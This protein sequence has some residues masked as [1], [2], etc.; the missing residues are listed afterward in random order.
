MFTLHIWNGIL[1]SRMDERTTLKMIVLQKLLE[2]N[3]KLSTMFFI[4]MGHWELLTW[5]GRRQM[6]KIC[7]MRWIFDWNLI[8]FLKSHWGQFISSSMDLLYQRIQHK[9]LEV[10]LLQL[11]PQHAGWRSRIQQWLQINFPSISYF[12]HISYKKYLLESLHI[13]KRLINAPDAPPIGIH[14]TNSP[15]AS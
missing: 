9:F 5:W 2:E 10:F 14:A 8:M 11:E 4:L 6:Q 1:V 15:W 12:F 3:Q 13:K 7:Q